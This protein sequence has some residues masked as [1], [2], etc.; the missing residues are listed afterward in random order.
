[1]SSAPTDPPAPSAE[2]RALRAIGTELDVLGELATATAAGVQALQD[3]GE[4]DAATLR[5]IER[6]TGEIL[7]LLKSSVLPRLDALEQWRGEHERGHVRL[8]AAGIR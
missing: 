8:V 3:A 2:A 4:T 7:A 5:R 1:M 6:D